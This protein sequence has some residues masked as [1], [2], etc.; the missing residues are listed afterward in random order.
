MSLPKLAIRVIF[1]TL[2]LVWCPLSCGQS[3]NDDAAALG[4]IRQLAAQKQWQE[5]APKIAAY[6]Q[7]HPDSAAA[8]VLQS[9]ILI[10]LGLAADATE[11]LVRF[12]AAHPRSIPAISAYAEFSLSLNQKDVAEKLFLRCT[13]YAPQDESVWKQLGNFYLRES[14]K[15]A[16]GAFQR[17]LEIAPHDPASMAGIAASRHQQGDESGALR[18]FQRAEDWNESAKSYDPM[19]DS[20][21]AGFLLDRNRDRE[22]LHYYQQALDRDPSITQARIGKAK[23]LIHLQEWQEAENELE[24]TAVIEDCRLESLNLLTKV[25]REQGK[26]RQAEAAASRAERL[27]NDLNAE[28]AA[29][30]HIAA[31]LKNAHALESQKRFSEAAQ[32]YQEVLNAHQH[33]LAAWMGDGRCEAEMGELKKAETA[34]RHMTELQDNSADAHVLLGKVLLREEEVAAARAE[35]IRAK[36]LDPLF[37]D[38]GLGQAASYM[39]ER[40]YADAIPIL[41]ATKSLPGAGIE[42]RLM[43]TEALY[44]DGQRSA[45]LAEITEAIRRYPHNEKAVVMRTSLM[46]EH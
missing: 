26:L 43:L 4:A 42:P 18:D 34:L 23:A 38:A 9:E 20:L 17:A 5:A 13:R 41:R 10:H 33:V 7:G 6:R 19:V 14:R 36:E 12:L 40:R 24:T 11:L 16:L 8:A 37:A 28:K 31:T 30:N 39:V 29:S 3:S 32:A 44:K 46:G 15:D 25:Y 22:S 27:S 1:S 21:F 2:A 45:A 35:F